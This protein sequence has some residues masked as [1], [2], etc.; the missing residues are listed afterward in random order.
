MHDTRASRGVRCRNA[1]TE[2]S[3]TRERTG[4]ITAISAIAISMICSS[5]W[6]VVR[7]HKRLKSQA[8]ERDKARL[9]LSAR[10]GIFDRRRWF[11]LLDNNTG[12]V[13]NTRYKGR[14]IAI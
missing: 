7:Q 2:N 10:T 12:G 8:L 1:E 9:G 6:V 5:K 13:G 3:D 4:I 11:R 14:R